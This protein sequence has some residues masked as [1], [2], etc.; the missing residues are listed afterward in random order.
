VDISTG[1]SCV[2]NPACI[3]GVGEREPPLSE[4]I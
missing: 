1:V 4:R 3:V 2:S